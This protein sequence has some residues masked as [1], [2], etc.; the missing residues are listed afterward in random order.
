MATLRDNVVS[1]DGGHPISVVI[2]DLL[3]TVGRQDD[4][5]HALRATDE[6]NHLNSVPADE[7][8]YLLANR[9]IRTANVES[10]A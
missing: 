3:A 8:D 2:Y 6:R 9:E 10:V 5:K 4:T 1:Y 7:E